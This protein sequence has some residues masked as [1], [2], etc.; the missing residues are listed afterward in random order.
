MMRILHAYSTDSNLIQTLYT[1]NFE[2]QLSNSVNI[3][4]VKD[5]TH[6]SFIKEYLKRIIY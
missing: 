3:N 5:I 1:N 2:E 4:K 6:L